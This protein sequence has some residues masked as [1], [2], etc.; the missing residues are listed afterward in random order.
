MIRP[1]KISEID[2]ILEITRACANY[3]MAKGIYQ[4]NEQYPSKLHLELDMERNELFVKTINGSIVGA[5]VISEHMDEEYLPVQWLTKNEKNIYIHRLC[6]HP[7]YQGEG[8]AQKMMS[9]AE[10]HAKKNG[11][12]SVRLDTFS[13]NKRNQ[14]FYET[15]GYQRLGDVHFPEQSEYAFHCYELVL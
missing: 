2:D 4:W 1:A 10:D 12:V 8:Y 14:K 13:Q 15:R 7:K 11:F 5:I 9:Y 6:V 3:M